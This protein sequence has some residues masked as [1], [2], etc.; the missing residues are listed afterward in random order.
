MNAEKND[1]RFKKGRVETFEEKEKRI[2]STKKSWINREDYIGDLI[3]ENPYIHNSWRGI[4]FSERSKRVGNSEEW[5]N[6]KTFYNDVVTTYEKGLVFRRKDTSMPFS[7]DNFV[8]VKS[9]DAKNYH[10]NLVILDYD[11]ESHTMLEWADKT[12]QS[13]WGIRNRYYKHKH[14]FTVKEIIYGK[15][16]KVNDKKPRDWKV[17]NMNIRKKTSKMVASYCFSDKK[18]KFDNICDMTIDWFI[19]NILTK[20][21]VYCGDTERIGADRIDNNDGHTM[22]NSVPCCYD[23]NCARNNNFTHEEM[24]ILGKTIREI[25]NKREPIEQEILHTI[26]EATDYQKRIYNSKIYQYDKEKKLVKIY[27][28]VEELIKLTNFKRVR[29]LAACAGNRHNSHKYKDSF[30]YYDENSIK[31]EKETFK[32]RYLGEVFQYDME[33]NL[34]SVYDHLKDVIDF[35]FN[36]TSVRECCI[37]DRNH[38]K[39]FKWKYNQ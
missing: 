33:D 21:C 35:G 34:I 5:N 32:N 27:D 11:G 13:I 18:K 25:K 19:E 12:N 8:W 10:G 31:D 6:F 3:K 7:K 4:R 37:G 39:G 1:G 26:D 36:K 15:E 2:A 16:K 9:E 23:C 17:C 30:W 24:L 28:N 22:N 14:D 20:T 38:Y 29:I